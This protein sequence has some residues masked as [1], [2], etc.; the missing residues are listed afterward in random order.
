[1]RSRGYDDRFVLGSLA[2][3]GCLGILIPP[4]IVMIIYG[5][6]VRQPIA[7]LFMGGILPGVLVASLFMGYIM[8]RSDPAAEESIQPQTHVD[9]ALGLLADCPHHVFH[10]R[11]D[12]LRGS[13]TH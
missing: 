13:D 6:A 4:S 10:Y 5:S 11:W 8:V 7:D 1:M 2:A 12:L 9:W 3:G